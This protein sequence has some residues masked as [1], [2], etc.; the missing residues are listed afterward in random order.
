MENLL[1]VATDGERPWLKIYSA[2]TEPTLL[3]QQLVD[4]AEGQGR[5]KD[6]IARRVYRPRR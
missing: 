5:R 6:R 1:G 3:L 2:T 4:A